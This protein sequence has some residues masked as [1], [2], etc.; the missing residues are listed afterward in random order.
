MENNQRNPTWGERLDNFIGIFNP[1]AALARKA[2]RFGL[3]L[4][5]GYDAAA[6]WRNSANWIPAD[7]R[8]EEINRR[9]RSFLRT[10]A[11]YLERN[12]EIVNS[13]LNAYLRN[14]VGKGFNLQVKTDDTEWNS[15]LESTWREWCKPG[16]C[17]VTG[18][19]SLTEILSMIVRR[20]LVDGGILL[21]KIYDKDAKIPFQIQLRE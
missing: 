18:Q 16:N 3:R 1:K 21:V 17:D 13:V 15:L 5:Q 9:S 4:A 8:A 2:A 20:K 12:S 14:V 11:R 19:Y 6:Q 7:G 10:K